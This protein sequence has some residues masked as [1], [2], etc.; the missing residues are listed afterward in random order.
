VPEV[1][2]QAAQGFDQVHGLGL[3]PEAPRLHVLPGPG[4][5]L[6]ADDPPGLA[7][8][9][10]G[11]DDEEPLFRAF[12]SSSPLLPGGLTRDCL[13]SMGVL[14]SLAGPPP[15]VGEPTG[16][17]ERPA[18]M[19]QQQRRPECRQERASARPEGTRGASTAALLTEAEG[20]SY[21]GAPEDGLGGSV[22]TRGRTARVGSLT[23]GSGM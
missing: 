12:P 3:G 15:P 13:R 11:G 23:G 6:L 8:E 18:R 9:A 19:A 21:L 22:A 2:D 7:G 4:A 16:R 10:L 14:L 17:S 1:L 20:R 5:G